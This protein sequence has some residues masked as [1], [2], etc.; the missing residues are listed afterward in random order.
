MIIANRRCDTRD[1]R[2]ATLPS[3]EIQ[4][5]EAYC[6]L[7]N[8]KISDELARWPRSVHVPLQFPARFSLSSR[9][10]ERGDEMNVERRW[11]EMQEKKLSRERATRAFHHEANEEA[12]SIRA[13]LGCTSCAPA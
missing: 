1:Y 10:S 13:P 8:P 4:N 2:C 9:G 6:G 12:R 5:A 11:E 7:P 3:S